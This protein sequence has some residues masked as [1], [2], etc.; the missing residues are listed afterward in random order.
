MDNETKVELDKIIEEKITY[1]KGM[2]NSAKIRENNLKKSKEI[3]DKEIESYNK[4]LDI[5]KKL[6]ELN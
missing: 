1:I 4:K 3:N 6:K 2:L 5:L